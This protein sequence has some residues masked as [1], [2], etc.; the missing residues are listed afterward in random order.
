M[1]LFWDLFWD[2]CPGGLREPSVP[3]SAQEGRLGVMPCCP[4]C[5]GLGAPQSLL[6]NL[7][8]WQVLQQPLLPWL[9]EMGF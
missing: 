3:C 5:V 4:V 8:L 9:M 7:W 1:W 6:T 2:L